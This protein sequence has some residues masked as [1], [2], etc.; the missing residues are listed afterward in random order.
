MNQPQLRGRWVHEAA[1]RWVGSRG[2]GPTMLLGYQVVAV[3]GGRCSAAG[4]CSQKQAYTRNGG[5]PCET[6]AN[7]SPTAR[8]RVPT[9]GY[10]HHG[11]PSTM[12]VKHRPFVSWEKEVIRH[13]AS[14]GETL[15]TTTVGCR[16]LS[17][18]FKQLSLHLA[19]N[20]RHGIRI[21]RVICF[22]VRTR[23]PTLAHH[24]CICKFVVRIP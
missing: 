16:A 4:I 21:L 17:P 14:T 11:R 5:I 19:N 22:K 1:G 3:G 10:A 18:I 12:V 8:A 7:V 9:V 23:I 15:T 24:G 6:D 2:N 20:C 13:A